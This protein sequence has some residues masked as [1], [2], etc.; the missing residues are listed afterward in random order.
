MYPYAETIITELLQGVC[1]DPKPGGCSSQVLSAPD[2]CGFFIQESV[3]NPK[4]DIAAVVFPS[5]DQLQTLAEVDAMVGPERTLLLVNKQFQRPVD[6]G[7]GVFGRGNRERSQTQL[8]DRYTY[9]FA[10]QELACRGEDVKLLY[11]ATTGWQSSM[12]LENEGD[13]PGTNK[14]MTIFPDQPE[15]PI[16]EEM[17]RKINELLP[18]PLWMR[19]M[20][21]ANEKGLKFTR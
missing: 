11:E 6:F 8:F 17:E 13:E 1:D 2:C 14:E 12:I 7:N 20:Q 10:F 15:R 19:K 4:Q 21:E 5:V 9:G 16:Y 3:S 18:E